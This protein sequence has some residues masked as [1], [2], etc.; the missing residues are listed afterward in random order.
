MVAIQP[1]TVVIG[2]LAPNELI[3]VLLN[4]LERL[5]HNAVLFGA[6]RADEIRRAIPQDPKWWETEEVEVVLEDLLCAL[7]DCA[8]SDEVYFGRKSRESS[9]LGFWKS[10]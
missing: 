3:P 4:E 8:G 7:T 1:G 9:E 5:D 6:P 2:K 10:E